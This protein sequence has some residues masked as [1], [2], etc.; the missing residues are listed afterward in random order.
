MQLSNK[1]YQNL[2][3]SLE[4]DLELEEVE[5]G[6]LI[7]STNN[8]P[9]KIVFIEKGQLRLIDEKR[10]FGSLTLLKSDA[11]FVLGLSQLNSLPIAEEARAS[12]LC[13]YGV[14][15]LEDL[16]EKSVSILNDLLRNS[17]D[18]FELP[19]VKSLLRSM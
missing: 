17:I 4:L 5:P 2:I 8:S 1:N 15:S 6:A 18:P 14:I 19:T 12:S 11:P 9:G 16:P 7:Y 3:T 13:S 10:T